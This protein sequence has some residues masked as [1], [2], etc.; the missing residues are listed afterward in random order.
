MYIYIYVYIYVYFIYIYMCLHACA[1]ICVCGHKHTP[2]VI[3]W[4]ERLMCPIGGDN[5][6]P[7]LLTLLLNNL[8]P[9][10]SNLLSPWDIAAVI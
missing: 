9:A 4:L 3:P 10:G 1:Y 5:Y 8:A 2:R 7:S 6:S